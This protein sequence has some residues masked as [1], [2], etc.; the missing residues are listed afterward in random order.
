MKTLMINAMLFFGLASQPLIAQEQKPIRIGEISLSFYAVAGGVVQEVLDKLGHK[1]EIVRGLHG[2]IYPKLA[3]GEVDILAAS[4]LPNAHGGLHAAAKDKTFQIATLYGDAKLYWA[5]PD[6]VTGVTSIDDLK[7]PDVLA[8]MDK[9]IVGIG[10]DS[11][12]MI[13]ATKILKDYSLDGAGYKIVN[14]TAANW[15][16]NFR[17]AVDDK[18]WVVMPLWQ[19]QWLN[20]AYK[21]RIL[22]EP[23][24]VYQTDTAYLVAA[25]SLKN[26]LPAASIKA[27]SQISLSLA[28]VTRMDY[29]VNVEKKTPREA[30]RQW[31]SENRQKF[32]AWF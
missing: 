16:A 10:P 8:K 17:K 6:Y 5:V 14:D 22:D 3:A 31:V 18:R 11:G 24:G 23:K 12:L 27:L 29:I 32:E 20:A 7:K 9:T 4:W 19:P 26:Q 30:A 28:D 13:G 1:Y 15:I 21:V 25:N 2:E